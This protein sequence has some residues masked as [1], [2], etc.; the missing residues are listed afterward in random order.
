MTVNKWVTRIIWDN[1]EACNHQYDTGSM[2]VQWDFN[3]NGVAT[4]A[5]WA[6]VCLEQELAE[7]LLVYHVH[8]FQTNPSRYYTHRYVR[9]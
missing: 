6:M 7:N 2:V 9:M 3:K 5:Q 1:N 8:H 4:Q